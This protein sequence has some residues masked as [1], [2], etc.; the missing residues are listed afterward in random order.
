MKRN[1]FFLIVSILGF[2]TGGLLLI[3]S[4]LCGASTNFIADIFNGIVQGNDPTH[5]SEI[6]YFILMFAVVYCGVISV[7]CLL[8]ASLLTAAWKTGRIGFAIGGGVI[9]TILA[10]IQIPTTVFDLPLIVAAV[11]TWIGVA[12]NSDH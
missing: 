2:A 3:L 1:S 11:L 10:V 7:I 12:K 8:G 4:L 6:T 5:L 9:F